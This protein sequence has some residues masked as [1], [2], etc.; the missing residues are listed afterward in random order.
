MHTV[1]NRSAISRKSKAPGRLP[2]VQPP[3]LPPDSR[4]SGAP[5]FP[6]SVLVAPPRGAVIKAVPLPGLEAG[7]RVEAEALLILP[8][9]PAKQVRRAPS[10]KKAP[11]KVKARKAKVRK[12]RALH[13][14]PAKKPRAAVLSPAPAALPLPPV[15][16]PLAPA[17]PPNSRALVKTGGSGMVQKIV[18]W[19]DALGSALIGQPLTRK[20]RRV[21]L[22]KARQALQRRPLSERA[23]TSRQPIANGSAAGDELHLL[24]LENDRL[25]R[26]L[27]LLKAALRDAGSARTPA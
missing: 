18:R 19:L 11:G 8:E 9:R 17:P 6:A 23:P 14:K 24:R 12:P 5:A 7:P 1:R 21:V 13:K 26:E 22:P 15:A 4:A 20:R 10:T 25:N 27:Q 3:F 2:K 16:P